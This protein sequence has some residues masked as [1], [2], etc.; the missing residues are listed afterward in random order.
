MFQFYFLNIN[1]IIKST[2]GVVVLLL[3]E[4]IEVAIANGIGIEIDKSVFK[5]A[6]SNHYLLL[7]Q[8][9]LDIDHNNQI[10]DIGQ[11]IRWGALHRVDKRNFLYVNAHIGKGLEQCEVG[12]A[13][14]HLA[15]DKVRRV[16]LDHLGEP[17]RG[18]H[19]RSRDDSHNDYQSHK[20][21]QGN[22]SDFQCFFHVKSI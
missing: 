16:F 3:V 14:L 11:C 19:H 9:L 5:D 17:S 8:Q 13:Q 21:S 2:G 12:F 6:F 18:S 4:D 1:E 10:V 22:S 20:G 7:S 15:V